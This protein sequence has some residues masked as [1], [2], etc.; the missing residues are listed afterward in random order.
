MNVLMCPIGSRGDVQPLIALGLGLRAAGH[1]V[2]FCAPPDFEAWITGLGFAYHA[3]GSDFQRTLELHASELASRP[4]ATLRAGLRFLLGEIDRQF[5]GVDRAAA[6]AELMIG[7]GLQLAARSVAEARGIPYFLVL[8]VPQPVP[9]PDHPPLGVP[10]QTLP[11]WLNRLSHRAM[12][13][14][15]DVGLRDRINAR[16]SERGL[17]RL[18]HAMNASLSPQMLLAFDDV[19][20]A[21][22]RS[23]AYQVTQVPALIYRDESPLSESLERFLQR[24]QPPVYIGFGSMSDPAPAHTRELIEEVAAALQRRFVYCL[25]AARA[26]LA[27]SDR[28]L[29]IRHAPHRQLFPRV[30]AIVHHG[31][32]GTTAAAMR[33]GR[34]QLVV[35]HLSDQYF[36]GHLVH[37]RG[38]GEAPIPRARLTARRLVARLRSMLANQAV[39][40]TASRVAS[41]LAGRDGV[42]AAIAFAENFAAGH[43]ALASSTA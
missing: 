25:G 40:D 3:V 6:D 24:G 30:A 32:A 36:N 39:L 15:L 11:G 22:G 35:P 10:H 38:L 7:L 43:P 26:D 18:P 20:A 31:G 13:A 27:S 1:A 8:P 14:L 21:K 29:V 5:E 2:G 33:S 42:A 34:P 16:R 12:W 28:C 4:V 9:S 23:D 17:D 37:G 41:Q 19:L